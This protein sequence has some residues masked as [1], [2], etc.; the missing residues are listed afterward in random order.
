I[1]RANDTHYGLAAGV[2][3]KDLARALQFV[4]QLEVGFVWV[5]Q[6]SA[7]Q[8]QA[9]IGGFKQSGYGRELGRYS[10][11]EYCEVKTVSIKID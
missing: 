3:T 8:F 9:P 1:K 6:Y 4:E 5:N 2:I 11:E 7:I 10:L